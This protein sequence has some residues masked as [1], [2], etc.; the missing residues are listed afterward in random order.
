GNMPQTSD[1][2]DLFFAPKSISSGTSGC[3]A[4][5]WDLVI[6]GRTTGFQSSSPQSINNLWLANGTGCAGATTSGSGILDN[7]GKTQLGD[8]HPENTWPSIQFATTPSCVIGCPMFSSAASTPASILV[9]RIDTTCP[10]GAGICGASTGMIDIG[11]S[12][13]TPKSITIRGLSC[14]QN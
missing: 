9:D 10:L 2:H 8:I 7:G 1:Y 6:N 13:G 14:T 4:N 12:Y 11:S 3:W 5:T